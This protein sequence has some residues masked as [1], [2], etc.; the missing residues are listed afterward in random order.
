MLSKLAV[1]GHTCGDQRV[2]NLHEHRTGRR[3]RAGKFAVYSPEHRLRREEWL[4]H[5]SIFSQRGFNDNGE[6]GWGDKSGQ[7]QQS[8]D[9]NQRTVGIGKGRRFPTIA[10]VR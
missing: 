5:A 1:F 6:G 9:N 7:V 3:K 8:T 10:T 4:S 2:R